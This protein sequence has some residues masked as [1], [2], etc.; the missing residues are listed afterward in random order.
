[1]SK[2]IGHS[3]TKA[4]ILF[5]I[6]GGF[7]LDLE[8]CFRAIRHEITSINGYA[9]GYIEFFG[10]TSLWMIVVGG[11]S[12]IAVG[13]LNEF[14]PKDVENRYSVPRYQIMTIAGVLMIFVI[15]FGSGLLFNKALGMKLWNY[16]DPLNIMNQITLAYLPLWFVLSVFAQWF[17]DVLRH[18]IYKE[19][20]PGSFWTAVKKVVP[21][22]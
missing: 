4:L 18:V 9:P 7:Y 13:L 17:D 3:L 6:F 8:V 21:G 5:L 15:E 19:E 1:M 20:W 22:L 11:L 12:G 10:H 14:R 2:K 16:T